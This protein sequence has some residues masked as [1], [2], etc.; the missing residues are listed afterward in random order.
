MDNNTTPKKE[1]KAKEDKDKWYFFCRYIEN[2]G[3]FAGS[4]EKVGKEKGWFGRL[5]KEPEFRKLYEEAKEIRE[6]VR[7]EQREDAVHHRAVE[8]YDRTVASGGVAVAVDKV[9][10]DKLL[11]LVYLK[12]HPELVPQNGGAGPT[13]IDVVLAQIEQATP[14]GQHAKAEVIRAAL[15][16]KDR[17]GEGAGSLVAL[18]AGREEGE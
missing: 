15:R 12:D 18:P 10:S 9:Y 17:L 13:N 5:Y 2:G 16:E 1:E 14:I 8:G 7:R 3:T 6:E 11:E 4:L